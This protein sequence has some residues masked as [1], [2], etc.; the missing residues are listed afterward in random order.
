MPTLRDVDDLLS[1]HYSPSDI[2][3]WT[4][5]GISINAP[6]CLPPGDSL[7]CQVV[8]EYCLPDTWK[9]LCAY[10][11]E[12]KMVDSFN[13]PKCSPRLEAV[14]EVM[15]RIF[16]FDAFNILS[17]YSDAPPNL[18]HYALSAHLSNGGIHLTTNFDRCIER[19][20]PTSTNIIAHD[21]FDIGKI[22]SSEFHHK[23][24]HIH[25]IYTHRRNDRLGACVKNI[26]S[27]L[28]PDLQEALL[29]LLQSKRL[30]IFWGYSGRDY[31]DINPFFDSL[32]NL[33]PVLDNIV[34]IWVRHDSTVGSPT[35][36]IWNEESE[37]YVILNALQKCGASVTYLHANTSEFLSKCA[38]LW[39]ASLLGSEP[40]TRSSQ[41][42]A[43]TISNNKKV[44]ATAELFS[45]MGIGREV[46]TLGNDLLT[47]INDQLVPEEDRI[48]TLRTL[49]QGFR[50]IGLFRKATAVFKSIHPNTNTQTVQYH[51]RLAGD[52]WL[53][54]SYFR[55]WLHFKHIDILH[56][57]IIH[58]ALIENEQYYDEYHESLI[59]LLHWFR[60]T[61]RLPSCIRWVFPHKLA[62]HA[63]NEL[64][65]AREY[66]S[67]EPHAR[68][69]IIRLHSEIELLRDNTVLPDWVIPYSASLATTFSETDSLFGVINFSRR[70]LNV[71][72]AAGELPSLDDLDLLLHRC[73]VIGDN[74]GLLKVSLLLK[75]FYHV[76][77]PSAFSSLHQVQWAWWMK[78]VWLWCWYRSRADFILR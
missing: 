66:I 6:T 52:A 27:G 40:V 45:S 69:K 30:I 42:T 48:R 31:F 47:I 46:T 5:A 58:S 4:G 15:I 28:T 60:D 10:F 33:I 23:I 61:Q 29:N 62:F 74:I 19:C 53:S 12:S 43:N 26:A 8:E 63:F 56:K 25:G 21:A 3:C 37:G 54:G 14:F 59:T 17:P 78:F 38:I 65:T 13:N 77:V 16:G 68:A 18:N 70:E 7:T 35:P 75:H 55:S 49:C 34:V 73:Q 41:S 2:I 57:R 67:R 39:N 44:M 72:I 36:K 64:C 22:S 11:V 1:G 76:N 24:I 9:R 20:L 32:T 51:N 71:R 50:D